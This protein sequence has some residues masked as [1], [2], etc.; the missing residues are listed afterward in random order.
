MNP[1]NLALRFLLEVIALV[2]AHYVWS[3]DRVAW[4][5]KQ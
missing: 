1:A 2:L 5:I 4:L 3:Y